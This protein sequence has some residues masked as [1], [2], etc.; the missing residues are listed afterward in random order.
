MCV[1][2]LTL[3]LCICPYR[4]DPSLCPHA[5]NIRLLPSDILEEP[6]TAQGWTTRLPT[7]L[8]GHV[9]WKFPED[10][11]QW[12]HCP[13]YKTRNRHSSDLGGNSSKILAG[14]EDSCPETQE[15]AGRLEGQWTRVVRRLCEECEDG[16]GLATCGYSPRSRPRPRPQQQQQ[17]QQQQHHRQVSDGGLGKQPVGAPD[18]VGL[19]RAASGRRVSMIP[20][21]GGRDRL[22]AASKSA[23]VKSD[24]SWIREDTRG[25][26]LAQLKALH[27][28]TNGSTRIPQRGRSICG[29]NAGSS[30]G[31][32]SGL[33]RSVVGSQK[34]SPVWQ[35]RE[36]R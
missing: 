30:N 28:D 8:Q 15:L 17:Q 24:E 14:R 3:T 13:L 18:A 19:R 26:A 22:S 23:S 6:F 34:K 4:D 5:S 16:H 33:A 10:Q 21:A 25:H 20:T 29:I 1:K 32:R 9:D 7:V 35:K 36:W 31:G 12:E 11:T 27:V 2:V